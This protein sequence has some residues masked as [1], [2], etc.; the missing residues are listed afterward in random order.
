M[1][2]LSTWQAK[3]TATDAPA[4]T[5]LIRLALYARPVWEAVGVRQ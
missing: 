3:L 4:A 1:A 2:Y 5:V